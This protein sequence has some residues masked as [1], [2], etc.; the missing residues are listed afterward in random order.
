MVL[1]AEK[2][3]I[4]LEPNNAEIAAKV[5]AL[6]TEPLTPQISEWFQALWKDKGIQETYKRSSEYQLNDNAKY[7]LENLDRIAKPDYVPNQGDALHTRVRTT[8]VVETHFN[9][10]KREVT[11][12]D[13][14]GQRAERRKWMNCFDT[15]TAVIFCIAL[16]EYDLKLVEDNATNRMHESLKIFEEVAN[17]W[18]STT[19]II[20]FLNKS[21]LFQQ[22]FPRVP[23]T[24]CFPEYTGPN[25][26]EPASDY[27]REKLIMIDKH[28]HTRLYAHI[29]CATDTQAFRLVFEAI[30]ETLINANLKKLGLV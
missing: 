1:A 15:V 11:L 6:Q 22:K 28:D 13:V 3:G 10:G 30:R 16:S 27:V 8:G 20:I 2:L 14:G 19:C 24:V 23:L 9:M 25:E 18:F 21:D 29:T 4:E 5:K 17:K 26:F 7:C 12:V